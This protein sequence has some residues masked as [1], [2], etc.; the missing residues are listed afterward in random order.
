MGDSS[1]WDAEVS[2]D[3]ANEADAWDDLL[4][5]ISHHPPEIVPEA[6]RLGFRTA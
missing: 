6:A 1:R 5:R 4:A 2:A 3:E